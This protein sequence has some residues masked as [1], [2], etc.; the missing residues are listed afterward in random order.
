MN[1]DRYSNDQDWTKVERPEESKEYLKA[2]DIA[3]YQIQQMFKNEGEFSPQSFHWVK[4][5]LTSPSFD[6]FSFGYKN[7]V[8]S[9]LIDPVSPVK[10]IFRSATIESFLSDERRSRFLSTAEENN[11]VP[12]LFPMYRDGL[13]PMTTGWYLLNAKTHE[14]IK[15]LELATD[16]RTP[17]SE[18]EKNN[19]AIQVVIQQMEKEGNKI[20]S[21]CDVIGVEPQIWFENNKGERCWV[22]VKYLFDSADNDYHKWIGLENLSPTLKKYDGFFAGVEFRNAY[23]FSPCLYRGEPANINFRGLQRVYLTDK[24]KSYK[25]DV[26]ETGK[27]ASGWSGNRYNHILLLVALQMKGLN[28]VGDDEAFVYSKGEVYCDKTDNM[29][30]ALVLTW[31]CYLAKV[32]SD[33]FETLFTLAMAERSSLVIESMV[34]SPEDMLGRIN[35]NFPKFN[36]FKDIANFKDFAIDVQKTLISWLYIDNGSLSAIIKSFGKKL[37]EDIME[38]IS[39]SVTPFGDRKYVRPQ[40]IDSEEDAYYMFYC[41]YQEGEVKI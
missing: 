8:F 38:D 5:E 27:S 23:D 19:F 4:A 17:M 13:R 37:Q 22:L 41:D 10:R 28:Y 24:L 34:M 18:W 15:P 16:E 35:V 14:W 9:V 20:L 36:P 31:L 2:R 12:C 39:R 32:D 6:D 21:F 40:S 29:C 30:Y 7:Q 33:A 26:S 3:G 1:N 25:S 11:L